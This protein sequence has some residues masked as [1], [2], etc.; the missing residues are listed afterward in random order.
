[1]KTIQNI[2]V[3]S[4]I[5][6]LYAVS[7]RA[8][9]NQDKEYP[10]S[11]QYQ[12]SVDGAVG[13]T[14]YIPDSHADIII[15]GSKQD[16]IKVEATVDVSEMDMDLRQEFFSKTKLYLIPSARGYKLS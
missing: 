14:L 11:K 9:D 7:V 3:M 4:M 2:I 8:A 6:F 15:T 16:G 5:L 10:F 13:K 12:K 1:M